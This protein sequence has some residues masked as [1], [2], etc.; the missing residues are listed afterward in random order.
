MQ[1]RGAGAAR[2][3]KIHA[4]VAALAARRHVDRADDVLQ[5]P[6]VK[7]NFLID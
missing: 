3:L 1:Q 4:E 7:N 5:K 6:E 2:R